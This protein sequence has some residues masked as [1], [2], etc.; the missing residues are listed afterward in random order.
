MTGLLLVKAR[1]ALVIAAALAGLLLSTAATS[2]P[3]AGQSGGGSNPLR[4]SEDYKYE[5]GYDPNNQ[6]ANNRSAAGQ[7]GGGSN[8]LRSSE[9]YKYE[10]GYDPNNQNANN[11]SAAGQSGGG[12]NPLRSSEDYKYEQGYDPNNQNTNNQSG[13]DWSGAS[14]DHDNRSDERYHEGYEDGYDNGY[15]DGYDQAGYDRSG[16]DRDGYDQTGYD[17]NGY[18]CDGYDRSGRDRNGQYRYDDNDRDHVGRLIAGFE[19]S[20]FRGFEA[21]RGAR[22]IG[23]RAAAGMRMTAVARSRYR[24]QAATNPALARASAH[25][26]R[27]VR[28]RKRFVGGRHSQYRRLRH[29]HVTVAAAFGGH[30]HRGGFWPGHQVEITRSNAPCPTSSVRRSASEVTRARS[31]AS[32]RGRL[33]RPAA[34]GVPARRTA[35][36]VD[37]R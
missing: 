19:V 11:R 3:A 16:Y 14:R 13:D 26:L 18:D 28:Q 22:C 15:E 8:P 5:Q 32:G 21:C 34:A 4:S 31:G 24:G 6:N 1:R 36:G 25:G 12:S 30:R 27:R 29:G 9:D 20:R 2:T 35:T 7:S 23:S 33:P 10:Q 17:R 37:A